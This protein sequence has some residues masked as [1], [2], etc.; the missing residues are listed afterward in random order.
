MSVKD[1]LAEINGFLGCVTPDV[2]INEALNNQETLL[3]GHANCERGRYYG[4]ESALQTLPGR[5]DLLKK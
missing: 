3:I 2:W 1:V 5:D 4:D